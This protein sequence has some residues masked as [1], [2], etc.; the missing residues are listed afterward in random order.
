MATF[1]IPSSWGCART[2]RRR[3]STGK[4]Q[5]PVIDRCTAC[6]GGVSPVS[7]I[8]VTRQAVLPARGGLA[9]FCPHLRL[10]SNRSSARPPDG[11]EQLRPGEC[12]PPDRR[13][14]LHPRHLQTPQGRWVCVSATEDSENL[15]G[16]SL[17]RKEK[18][19][20]GTCR[21]PL[22]MKS[23]ASMRRRQE[24]MHRMIMGNPPERDVIFLNYDGLDCRKRNL[25]VVDVV[26]SRRHH[27]VRRETV[28][29]NRDGFGDS[30]QWPL[31]R[32][33][34]VQQG[35]SS[36]VRT[37]KPDIPPPQRP[38]KPKNIPTV[39]SI[40]DEGVTAGNG[41]QKRVR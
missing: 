17:L 1:G 3:T 19:N 35:Y 27:R 25:R 34:D 39:N 21:L 22:G 18:R 6:A 30:S 40:D 15:S 26:E 20:S 4:C 13:S 8:G 28:G 14:V 9:I 10:H 29:R 36:A 33:H 16:D 2:S 31:D 37:P 41:L 11:S 7:H 32:F 5:W 23:E 12:L 24:S 38:R